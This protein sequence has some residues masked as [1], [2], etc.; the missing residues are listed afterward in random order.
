VGIALLRKGVRRAAFSALA[1]IVLALEAD[2][3]GRHLVG[4]DPDRHL[5]SAT[6]EVFVADSGCASRLGVRRAKT[7]SIAIDSTRLQ[8]SS[9]AKA[10]MPSSRAFLTQLEANTTAS[11][12]GQITSLDDVTLEVSRMLGGAL[13]RRGLKLGVA[14]SA[15]GGLIGHLLTEVP[16]SSNYF[17]GAV[18]AYSN[19]V[20]ANLL[21]VPKMTLERHGAVSAETATAMAQ[22]VCRL[23]K[24][25]VG[26]ASTGIAGPTGAT[27][28][29]PV[30]LVYIAVDIPSLAPVVRRYE[31]KGSRSSLKTQF[32]KIALQLL[33]ESLESRTAVTQPS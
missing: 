11:Q 29:K 21:H 10:V 26:L 13:R 30:G 17:V 25:D 31:L 2:A 14:E 33:L 9:L 19:A 24:S 1:I 27:P 7:L 5:L 6:S 12:G 20:K 32:A 8:S 4:H 16:G 22:G 15:T 3:L 18:V 28:S 23:L